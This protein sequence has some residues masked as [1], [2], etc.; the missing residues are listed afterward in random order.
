MCIRDSF[1]VGTK[2][3]LKKLDTRFV[4]TKT[5]FFLVGTKPVLEGTKLVLAG[6]K[7]DLGPF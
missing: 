2:K 3:V 5:T 1:L 6:T 7:P 4:P